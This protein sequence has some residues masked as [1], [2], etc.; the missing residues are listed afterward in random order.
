MS[1]RPGR[2]VGEV[3]IDFPRPR[4]RELLTSPEFHEVCDQLSVM[5]HGA[6]ND[7]AGSAA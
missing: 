3:E 7:S 4:R 5:L 6:S 1:P 2:I